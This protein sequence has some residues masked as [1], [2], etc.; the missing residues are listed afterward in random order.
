MPKIKIYINENLLIL[1]TEKVAKSYKPSKA[2][3][4]AKY[5]G[6]PRYL[7]RYV[8]LLEK[9]KTPR[10]VILYHE[11]LELLKAHFFKLYQH[12]EAGG[13]VVLNEKGEVLMIFRKNHW[14]MAKGHIE[15]GETKEEAAIREV[16][17]ETGLKK[18]EL[19][20]FVMTTYHTYKNRK[21]ERCMKISH[22]YKMTST[23]KKCYP[24][25][26]EGI[27]KVE[28]MPYKTAEKITPIFKNIKRVL[29][30]ARKMK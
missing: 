17:E 2:V 29:K 20:D 13:G 6:R 3:L 9:D 30:R 8:D 7:F 4:V 22:W 18:I 25:R 11:D 28:W 15:K 23:S 12:H 10:K 16:K 21:K 27:E 5:M 1:T 24:Q 19:G 26:E 14:D